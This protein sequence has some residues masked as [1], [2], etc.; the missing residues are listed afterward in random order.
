MT[1][2]TD[3]PPFLTRYG[4]AVL[5]VFTATAIRMALT[6]L[7]GDDVPFITFFPAIIAVAW[8]GGWR[9]AVLS[10]GLFAAI[11]N[12]LFVEP[13][14]AFALSNPAHLAAL[15]IFIAVGLGIS[16]IT[17]RF[18]QSRIS[19]QLARARA[20]RAQRDLRENLDEVTRMQ[21]V[22]T[23]LLQA[24]DISE[25]LRDILDAAIEI[26]GADMGNIQML[27]GGA[28]RITTHRGFDQAF[29]D[30]FDKVHRDQAACG[31]ALARGERVIVEDVSL[32]P[33]FVG[34]SALDAM[35][36]A[37][38][39][40]VQ[41]TPL[42]SRSGRAVGMFS[43]HYRRAPHRPSDRALGL[44]DVLARQAADVI[45]QRQA[46]EALR[47]KEAELEL[48][49]EQTPFLLTRCT[50][51][52][53]YK[54]VSRAYAEMLGR[55]PEDIIGRPIVDIM[56]PAAFEAI[57][58]HVERVLQ[59]SRVEYDADVPFAEVGMRALRVIYSPDR[60][61]QG[62]VVGWLASI[63]D[64][65]DHKRSDALRGLLASIVDSSDDAISSKD[66][67]GII[68]SWNAGAERLFGYTAAEAI[69]QPMVRVIP[70]DRVDEEAHI[71]S[72]IRAGQA[73]EH[74]ETERLTKDGRRVPVSIT[75]SPVR[76]RDGVVTGASSIA[77]DIS[78]RV[79][80]L[81]SEQTA[82]ARAEA[83]GRAKDEFL[84]TVSHELRTPLNAIVGWAAMLEEMGIQDSR[85]A[86]G[87]HSIYRNTRALAQLVDDLLDVSR[88]ISGKMRLDVQPLDFGDV[89]DAAVESVL[90]AA[91]AKDIAIDVQIDPAAR[92][93]IG[94]PARLQQAVWNLLSNAIKFTPSGGRVHVHARA[95]DG[96]T[97]LVV[98]DTGIGI[99]A[100]F[101]PYVFDRFRQ[102]DPSS[103]RAHSGLGLGL[104]IVRHL[105]ELHG[106]T[107]HV[108]SEGRDA[109]ARFAIRLPRT[110]P[111]ASPDDR[112]HV[113]R[114]S[115]SMPTP[116]DVR[117]DRLRILVVDDDGESCDVMREMLQRLGACVQVAASVDQAVT[118]LPAF[119]PDLVLSD[120]A[121]PGRDGFGILDA[122]RA[123]G[124]RYVPVVAV[125]AYARAEDRERVMAAG[126]DDYLAKPVE[127]AAL[128]AIVA[129]HAARARRQL[130]KS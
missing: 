100:A 8:L 72:R 64:L 23:R 65:T 41:S 38:A 84:A 69:G 108:T 86:R 30:F 113:V 78:D 45:E 96:H 117:L 13:H 62:R 121:M 109:G 49:V 51:D 50:R 101:L 15:A 95:E 9:P 85:A 115:V 91:T 93:M 60:D 119:G 106:G 18:R 87:V 21:Q 55:R 5:A 70:E 36:A 52:L 73:V 68:T 83:A 105:A 4:V 112:R 58:A 3:S 39:R 17:G 43:T 79:R 66:L 56:G 37:G 102:A 94:D 92:T 104:A 76:N 33:I 74:L 129:G 124:G 57:R 111:A 61:D 26:T 48:V 25:V 22:S 80:L 46:Q 120:L 63:L 34:T 19:E 53:R 31:A 67:N 71:L 29:L 126:F 11:A 128:A 20:E 98:T 32:D 27:E 14:G 116:T 47:A 7:L 122:V 2:H 1:D 97:E 125:T 81:A 35:L 118:E 88:M 42:V 77:R 59:G 75:V 6:P 103:T 40:A 24:G 123:M 54:F 12:Y 114:D 10:T 28:L 110:T 107:V 99:E 90:P 130:S 44:L 89:I 82:R 127:P 16:A